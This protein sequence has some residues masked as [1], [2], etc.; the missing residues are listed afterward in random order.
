M[1]Y[2]HEGSVLLEAMGATGRAPALC[3][4]WVSWRNN[5]HM[6]EDK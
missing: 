4:P 2:K 3:E 1:L 5:T 6:N